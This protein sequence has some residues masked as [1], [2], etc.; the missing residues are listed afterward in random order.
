V[1]LVAAEMIGANRGI[2]ALVLTA[3]NLMQID[4]LLAGVVI[5]SILGL[6]VSGVLGA[7]ERWL[8]AWR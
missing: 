5:L 7:A 1:L 6:M 3:G 4:D 2:G 8:L